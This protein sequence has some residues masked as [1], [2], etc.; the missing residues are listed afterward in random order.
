MLVGPLPTQGALLSRPR[1]APHDPSV[2]LVH[3]EGQ[4]ALISMT[5]SGVG[6]R[7]GHLN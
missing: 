6:G 2:S 1:Q 3:G 7:R 5:E 4:V